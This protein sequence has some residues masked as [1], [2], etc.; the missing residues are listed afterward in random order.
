MPR[1]TVPQRFAYHYAPVNKDRK[2][3][4]C[5]QPKYPSRLRFSLQELRTPSSPLL[6]PS[7]LIYCSLLLLL[8]EPLVLV[9]HVKVVKSLLQAH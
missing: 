3:K 8:A 5:K 9:S 1:K 2:G 4:G 6:R 7:S